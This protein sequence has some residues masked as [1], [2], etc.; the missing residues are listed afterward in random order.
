MSD[1]NGNV[2]PWGKEVVQVDASEWHKLSIS[3]LM[4]QRIVLNNRLAVA[5]Q[6]GGP[7]MVVQIQKGIAM[8]DA[9]LKQKEQEAFKKTANNTSEPSGLI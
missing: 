1:V 8:L 4:D 7:A 5:S 2:T 6:Y 9:I 3:D